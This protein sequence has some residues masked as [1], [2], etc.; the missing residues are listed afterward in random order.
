MADVV[1]VMDDTLGTQR[2]LSVTKDDITAAGKLRPIGA[3]HFAAQAQLMQNLTALGNSQIAQI[4][5]PHTSGVAMSQLVE[6]V[7][8]LEKFQLFKPNIAV[9]E[10]LETERLARQAQEE[11]AMEQQVAEGAVNAEQAQN[12]PPETL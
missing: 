12:L 3:R 11:L 10:Q 7:L 4:I 9:E 1:R 5:A 6:E 8:G 2:F